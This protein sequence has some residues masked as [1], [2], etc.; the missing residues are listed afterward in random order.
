MLLWVGEAVSTLGSQITLVAFPLL[1][2]ATTHSAAK[3]GLIGFA[4]Q[5]PVLALYLPAGVLVD[6]H[7]R[8]VIMVTSSLIGAVALASVPVALA[9]G[10]LPFGQIIVVAFLAGARRI[11]Y[12]LA[13]QGALPLVVSS[14]QVAEAVIGNQARTEGA[15]LAGPPVGG[16]LFAIAKMLP[17]VLDAGSYLIAALA[18]CFVSTPL[19]EPRRAERRRAGTE[20]AEAARWFWAQP[21]LR[22]S[23]VAVSASN[24][25]AVGVELVLIVR[26]RQHGASPPA[27]GAM[28]AL[29]GL[30]GLLGA[31]LAT[32]ITQHLSPRVIV[33]GFFWV[34]T[35][36]LVPLAL[37]RD[38]YLLG[39]IAAIAA[40]GAPAW[41]AIVVGARLSLTPDRLRGRVTSV[42]RLISG[43]MLA[44]GPLAAGTLS[45]TLGTTAALVAFAIWQ[46]LVSVAGTATRSLRA[47][48]I[49]QPDLQSPEAEHPGTS[50]P[51]PASSRQLEPTLTRPHDV[52]VSAA[53]G[54]AFSAP[55]RA[56]IA[57]RP[58][59]RCRRPSEAAAAPE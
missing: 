28:L 24:F 52:Q 50:E 4:N 22:A 48:I 27:V 10:H 46:S 59:A 41:N 3:A 23:A 33:I 39:A 15:L 44:I 38:P 36:L 13:E 45:Q 58:H 40:L 32:Q 29:I 26:T 2:L 42:A 7:D 1:V 6:R 56:P 21:F 57:E 25:T 17:F 5:V 16:V 31:A 18:T 35:A 19:Q 9:L 11:L 8:R 34:Q 30:G 37:T 47:G 14:D 20:I 51:R 53:H 49:P 43:S 54:D 12:S 55:A